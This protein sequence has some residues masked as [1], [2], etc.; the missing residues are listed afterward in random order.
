M[1]KLRECIYFDLKSILPITP[2]SVIS[3][4][5]EIAT[6][7]PQYPGLWLVAQSNVAVK[8]IA[9]K[10]ASIGYMNWKLLVSRDFIFDW[11][12]LSFYFKLG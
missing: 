1:E 11:Y 9:E 3:R 6:A 5:V 2:F 12:I 7:N 8:N 4:F 10:L